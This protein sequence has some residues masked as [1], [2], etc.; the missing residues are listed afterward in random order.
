MWRMRFTCWIT[1][2]TRTHSEYV[3]LIM[4]TLEIHC[5]SRIRV[6]DVDEN[7]ALLTDTR[8]T[9]QRL[10]LSSQHLFLPEKLS[11]CYKPICLT[12]QI[13]ATM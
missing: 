2:A 12:K 13:H 4:V 10:C 1:K 5:L 6:H 8:K 3:A 9:R 7:S 11:N